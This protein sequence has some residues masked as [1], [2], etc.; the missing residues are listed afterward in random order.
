MKLPQARRGNSRPDCYRAP[1]QTPAGAGS[2]GRLSAV[3]GPAGQA[4]AQ[5]SQPHVLLE[6]LLPVNG[7]CSS[8]TQHAGWNGPSQDFPE[9]SHP[10]MTRGPSVRG[11]SGLW[12]ASTLLSKDTTTRP[13]YSS[14]VR[15]I[16]FRSSPIANNSCEARS[17]ST[18]RSLPSRGTP[19]CPRGPSRGTTCS[20]PSVKVRPRG[21][22]SGPVA[23]TATSTADYFPVQVRRWCPVR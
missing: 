21:C 7:A 12:K 16:T 22:C 2:R 10:R 23:G 20:T 1:G 17:A 3:P 4:R 13:S 9:D 14:S 19:W 15:P 11:P 6:S 8:A 5:V 18:A